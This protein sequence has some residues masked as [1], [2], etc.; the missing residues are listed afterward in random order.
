MIN[1]TY[2]GYS[3]Q[4]SGV[5]TADTD[6]Y[7]VPNK[8]IQ[9][10]KL[11][12][13]DGSVIV[14]ETYES[15]KF[16]CNGTLMASSIAAMDTLIDTF[17]TA[18]N[19]TKQNFDI[20]YAGSTRRYIATPRNVVITRA[21]GLNQAGWS[22]EFFCESP[23]G[24]DI[25]VSTLIN[26]QKNLVTNPSFESNT[27]GYGASGYKYKWSSGIHALIPTSATLRA[28]TAFSY[29]GVIRRATAQT[30]SNEHIFIAAVAGWYFSLD[31]ATGMQLRFYWDGGSSFYSTGVTLDQAWHSVT[32]TVENSGSNI[33]GKFYVDGVLLNT[34]TKAGTLTPLTTSNFDLGND[35]TSIDEMKQV[36]LYKSV[37]TATEVLALHQGTSIPQTSNLIGEYLFEEGTGSVL[38]DTSGNGNNAAITG[39]PWVDSR[40]TIERVNEEAQSGTYSLSV[41]QNVVENGNFE[42]KPITNVSQTQAN[43]IDGTATGSATN[44]FNWYGG[45]ATAPVM[46]DT[47]TK[48]AGAAS[49]KVSIAA[50][51]ASEVRHGGVFNTYNTPAGTGFNLN[52]NVNYKLTYYMKTNYISGDSNNGAALS[53]LPA[54]AAGTATATYTSSY[55]KTTTDWTLYTVNFTTGSTDARGHVELRLYGQSGAATL[56]MDAWYDNIRIEEVSAARPGGAKYKATGLTIS[57]VYTVSAYIKQNGTDYCGILAPGKSQNSVA[58]N[59]TWQRVSTTFT[60]TATTQDLYFA[61]FTGSNAFYVDAVQV[62]GGTSPTDYQDYTQITTGS[63]NQPLVIQ[64]SYKAEPKITVYVQSVTGGSPNKTITIL[65]ASTLRGLSVTRSWVA[66]DVLEIDSMNKTVYV[67]SVATPSTGLYP[68]WQP[69]SGS[70]TYIDD[71]TTRASAVLVTYTKRYL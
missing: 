48:Y 49:L 50:G 67:N 65:N 52:P 22:I 61:N 27:T 38:T 32:L 51:A 31:S 2:G 70:L 8:T 57:T 10:E 26:T 1:M 36:R 35:A 60:A 4:A 20:D 55:V 29:H 47:A 24:S 6:I 13:S 46:F 5:T 12:E 21:H 39:S 42:R 71:F 3:L 28:T 7:S 14:K 69:G 11:A 54:N 17:K 40:P 45:G 66:G 30:A 53:V 41:Y 44:L 56:A 16:T 37:L 25:A 18:M 15:K 68:T 34:Q 33:V 63:Y 43:Y 58:S 9:A 19:A 62:E 64:G 59:N 23:S